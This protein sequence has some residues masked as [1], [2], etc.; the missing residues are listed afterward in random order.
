[1]ARGQSGATKWERPLKK[2]REFGANR[3]VHIVAL[4][5]ITRLKRPNSR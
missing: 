3:T 4:A 1:M 2:G 5:Q